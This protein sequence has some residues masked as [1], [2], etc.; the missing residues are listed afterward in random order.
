MAL[1]SENGEYLRIESI[2]IDS[3]YVCNVNY[4]IYANIQHRQTGDTEFLHSKFGNVNSGALQIKLNENADNT[5]S[6][7]N[8]LKKASYEAIKQDNFEFSNWS[9]C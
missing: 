6:I 3:N 8:N 9:D 1:I 2:I 4:K 7:I 5:L